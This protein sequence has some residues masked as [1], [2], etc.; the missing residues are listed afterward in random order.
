MRLAPLGPEVACVSQ[1]DGR[2]S[3][4]THRRMLLAGELLRLPA[5]PVLPES[6]LWEG[7][8]MPLGSPVVY[9]L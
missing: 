5:D 2:A 4:Q 7:L 3:V 8:H 6:F 9:F 1:R